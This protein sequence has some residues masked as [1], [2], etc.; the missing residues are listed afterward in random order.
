ML[1]MID[2]YDS[3]TY[4]LVQY[5]GELG[6]EILVYRNDKI[7]ITEIEALSPERIVVSPGPC[8][9][10]EAGLSLQLI[11]HFKGKLPLLGVCLGH[12]SIGQ[13]FGGTIVHAK[14]IMHGKTS[15]IYHNNDDVFAGLDNPF[16]A[17]RY[18]S[19]VIEQETLPDCL[20][21]TAWTQTENGEVDEIMGVRHKKYAISGVQF[22]PES[23]LTSYGHE[24]LKNFLEIDIS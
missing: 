10:N 21:V 8:T 19:L 5:F 3:F 4:N 9:P 12:Q 18:H 1:L 2:N 11:E 13:A 22:H 17:T 6:E 24:L 7:S 20:E 23:I 14:E 15:E 16:T